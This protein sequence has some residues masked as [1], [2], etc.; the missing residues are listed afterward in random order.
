MNIFAITDAEAAAAAGGILGGMLAVF[1]VCLFAFYIL[2]VI[3]WWKIFT[4]AGE[5]GWKALIP[6]YNLVVAFRLAGVSPWWVLAMFVL[7]FIPAATGNY[8]NNGNFIFTA[9]IF[10]NIML[11]V[12]TFISVFIDVYFAI[13]LAKAFK[14]GIGFTIGLIFLPNIFY[15][16]LGFGKAKYN[17]KAALKA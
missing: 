13:R 17:K 15:L 3:A 2:T 14:K 12:A 7:A 4:K 9:N 6:I 1:L 8:D 11:V 16:I 10:G 5:K